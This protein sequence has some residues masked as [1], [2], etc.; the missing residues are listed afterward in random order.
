MQTPILIPLAT[1]EYLNLRNRMTPSQL[2]LIQN[3]ATLIA[4]N[5]L[6]MMNMDDLNDIKE[7]AA[8]NLTRF[9]GLTREIRN[10]FGLRSST[11]P[12]TGIWV[13]SNEEYPLSI[14][15]LSFDSETHRLIDTKD[16]ADDHP[17]HPENFS[18]TCVEALHKLLQE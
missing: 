17:C 5:L 15:S 8:D 3:H 13:K 18:Q 7:S 11:H 14:S 9:N 6:L 10:E 12:I 4:Q 16:I 2:K 1:P